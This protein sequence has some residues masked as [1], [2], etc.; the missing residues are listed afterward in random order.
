[1]TF[2]AD[3]Q[4]YLEEQQAFS[5]HATER[6][7]QL[8]YE[9]AVAEGKLDA[10]AHDWPIV[11]KR[12]LNRSVDGVTFADT[13]RSRPSLWGAL[14]PRIAFEHQLV[15][16][17]V[18]LYSLLMG[19]LIARAAVHP[20]A[21]HL[22]IIAQV[23]LFGSLVVALIVYVNH[24]YMFSQLK[25]FGDKRIVE[26]ERK[27]IPEEFREQWESHVA[28]YEGRIIRPVS[29][30]YE[31]PFVRAAGAYF[32]PLATAF[33]FLNAMV[34]VGLAVIAALLGLITSVH[35]AGDLFSVAGRV[36]LGLI[37]VPTLM[38][39]GSRLGFAL[40][41]NVKR[42]TALLVV[43]VALAFV[44]QLI[45]Y[46]FTGKLSG[47]KVGL[48]SSIATGLLGALGTAIAETLKRPHS[49]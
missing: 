19:W 20:D 16:P 38:F 45:T 37:A 46:V 29:F 22:L 43:A 42:F 32:S 21:A 25:V 14:L 31:P 26:A 11:W 27:A 12:L 5:E 1:M 17:L 47:G 6:T 3:D 48:I 40:M 15:N 36:A 9:K 2:G 7:F 33:A 30:E 8:A 41:Q 35:S 39:L 23:G 10:T 4:A 28:R 44:P 49:S 18:A 13:I 34:F 24:V